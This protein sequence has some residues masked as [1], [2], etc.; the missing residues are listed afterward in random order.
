MFVHQWCVQY[1]GVVC[2]NMCNELPPSLVSPLPSI[3]LWTSL[4]WLVLQRGLPTMVQV[5][6]N[7]RKWR[8]LIRLPVT[9][10]KLPWLWQICTHIYM[11]TRT[12]IFGLYSL[13]LTTQ[14]T[15]RVLLFL[16]AW[17][18]T[19]T[20]IFILYNLKYMYVDMHGHCVPLC[21]LL[22]KSLEETANSVQ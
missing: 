1:C 18:L 19:I 20:C 3:S 11:H 5:E 6:A 16:A 22:P 4:S 2:I 7:W 21:S 14:S 9:L 10:E 8:A 15:Q 13:C 17:R 12:H